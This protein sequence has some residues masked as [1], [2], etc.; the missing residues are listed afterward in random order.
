MT[1]QKG[2]SG[3]ARRGA[4]RPVTNVQKVLLEQVATGEATLFKKNGVSLVKFVDEEEPIP[5]KDLACSQEIGLYDKRR[6]PN[7]KE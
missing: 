2:Q 5:L 3:G 7:V 6:F 1:G 4:G